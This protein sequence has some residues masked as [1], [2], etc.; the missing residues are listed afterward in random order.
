[1]IHTTVLLHIVKD[2][3]SLREFKNLATQK[4][5]DEYK[6][7]GVGH[8]WKNVHHHTLPP[9]HNFAEGGLSTLCSAQLTR[10]TTTVHCSSCLVML[11]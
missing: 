4:D 9:C 10:V 7:R 1:M 8:S 11:P 2:I 6:T 3:F 5:E